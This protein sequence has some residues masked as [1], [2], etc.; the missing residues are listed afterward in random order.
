MEVLS[1][2]L[3]VPEVSCPVLPLDLPREPCP[4]VH[5]RRPPRWYTSVVCAQDMNTLA[6]IMMGYIPRA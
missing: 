4:I 6:R 5:D 3:E 1:G 2:E